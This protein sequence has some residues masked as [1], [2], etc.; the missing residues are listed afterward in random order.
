MQVVETRLLEGP[1][2]F[3][4][5]P[6]VKIEFDCSDEG[7]SESGAIERLQGC[8]DLVATIH[9]RLGLSRP[10]IMLEPLETPG[11][12]ALVFGWR[13]RAFAERLVRIVSQSHCSGEGLLEP[14]IDECSALI[15][16][17]ETVADAPAMVRN[18]DRK[19]ITIG[20]TGTN[21]KTTTT[22]LVS[23]IF[24]AAGKRV[25]WSSSS[26]VYIAGEEVLAGDYSGPRGAV[27]VLEDS[28]VD[29][30]VIE[31]ARG[32]ILLKG[33]A[34][35][36]LDVS[37]FINISPDHLDLQGIR[38]VEGL[39][40]TKAVV[41]RITRE[42]GFAVLN[43][44]DPLVMESTRDIAA[45][46]FLVS[47]LPEQRVVAAHVAAGG[48]AM[49][50]DLGGMFLACGTERTLVARLAGI[51]M[52][53]GGLAGFMIE[54]AMC[55][56]A[57]AFAAGATLEQVSEGLIS[58]ENSTE[59]N[60]GRLNVFDADGVTVIVDYAHN[61]AGLQALLEFAQSLRKENARLISVIG[62]AGDRTAT[63]LRELGR[64]AAA[65]SDHVIAKGTIKYLRGRTLED[66]VALYIEGIKAGG[67][68][69]F[70]V[71]PSER[72]GVQAALEMARPGDVIAAMAHEETREIHG[73]LESQGATPR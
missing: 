16:E 28:S 42:D 48:L 47:K 8:V 23:H 32:G 67:S 57:G 59:Q 46:R 17:P 24:T 35:E 6:A 71:A 39:A 63:S 60:P 69:P 2:I 73:Y 51:P 64:I 58:F 41:A 38:S 62:S 10:E 34:C 20:V 15:A 11:H 30:A 25:G 36:S 33:I 54:N 14:A 44:D 70:T 53:H 9:K 26:G 31:T 3:L 66:L 55:G 4:L 43:A 29:V 19:P 1:N 49:V 52:T 5:S 61:E 50:C 65:Q 22:R 56:A 27:R 18:A 72:S 13:R 40:R 21:G 68:T 45:T 37:I 12:I 7:L